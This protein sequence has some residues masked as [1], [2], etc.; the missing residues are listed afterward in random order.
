MTR[1]GGILICIILIFCLAL[2]VSTQA[3][4]FYITIPV[5]D[6]DGVFETN[7]QPS[8]DLQTVLA[9]LYHPCVAQSADGTTCVDLK[10]LP[11]ILSGLTGV[12]PVE[13]LAVQSSDG[14][15]WTTLVIPASVYKTLLSQ[16]PDR[17]Y[18]NTSDGIVLRPLVYPSALF[19]D[20]IPPI[21]TNVSYNAFTGVVRWDTNEYADTFVRWGTIQGNYGSSVSDAAW[22]KTHQILL[23]NPADAS[24]ILI[25]STD[26]SGNKSEYYYPGFSVS[27]SVKSNQGNPIQG[28]VV[29]LGPTL[30]AVTDATGAYTISGVPAGSFLLT[31]YHDQFDFTSGSLPI[32]VNGDT[33]GNNFIGTN[34]TEYIYMPLVRNR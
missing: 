27:G 7:V 32:T 19:H 22:I 4:A 31:V 12:L 20:T 28:A 25:S 24:Y 8:S 26:R 6:A 10:S 33:Q 2:A 30:V 11:T 15:L 5:T 16:L 9:S 13:H 17:V 1:K 18:T 23:Q 21:I 3:R 34:R 29:S 14:T